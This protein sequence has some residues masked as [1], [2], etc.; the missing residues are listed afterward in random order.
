MSRHYCPQ[1]CDE[2]CRCMEPAATPGT[3]IH[4]GDGGD[5]WGGWMDGQ[6]EGNKVMAQSL[7]C[8]QAAEKAAKECVTKIERER[9]D[10][11]R[12]V[13]VWRKRSDAKT[14]RIEE[15]E[16]ALRSV[17]EGAHE[18]TRHCPVCI[19]QAALAAPASPATAT[20][21]EHCGESR[22]VHGG[23]TPV[24]CP[25]GGGRLFRAADDSLDDHTGEKK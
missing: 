2:P 25:T 14:D 19:A 15:L 7:A 10:Y 9:D 21:C 17:A 18:T 13:E 22:D 3:D 4:N 11:A 20:K 6:V 23:E 8:A 5:Y 1:C 12:L 24:F 16:M